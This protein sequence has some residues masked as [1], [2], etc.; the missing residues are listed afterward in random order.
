VCCKA[1]RQSAWS[2]VDGAII[3]R[4][5]PC[6]PS[7]SHHPRD[8]RRE[9]PAVSIECPSTRR[10]VG[11]AWPAVH[12]APTFQ[13]SD[14]SSMRRSPG[15]ADTDTTGAARVSSRL[16]RQALGRHGRRL[17]AAPLAGRLSTVRLPARGAPSAKWEGV[18]SWLALC[19]DGDT[20]VSCLVSP[21][22]G[23]GG[24]W[25]GMVECCS[26]VRGVLTRDVAECR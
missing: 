21:A 15:S 23:R 9:A 13:G 20:R 24:M 1:C 12:K 26:R 3:T 5:H 7:V 18:P 16:T 6:A 2:S 22:W 17:S 8:T 11:R 25:G 4:D 14:A 19:R 10:R